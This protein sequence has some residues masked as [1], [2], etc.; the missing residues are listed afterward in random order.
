MA[1]II[2]GMAR[3]EKSLAILMESSIVVVHNNGKEPNEWPQELFSQVGTNDE[4]VRQIAL[5]FKELL[6]AISIHE[7]QRQQIGDAF[8]VL[9]IEGLI[10]AYGHL[11]EI[12]ATTGRQIP[13]LTRRQ[14][15][16]DFTSALWR[17]YK[18]LTPKAA[19]LLGFDLGFLFQ[20][21]AEFDRGLVAF[22]TAH[23]Q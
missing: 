20:G 1:D 12:R 15:F 16:E 23:P 18:T 2:T 22:N 4:F 8:M 14:Q 19:K 3:Y 9:L 11:R 17:V 10:P 13:V 21:E 6:G 5:D 7:P